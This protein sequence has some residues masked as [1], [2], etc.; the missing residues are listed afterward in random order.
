MD[1]DI[2]P[3]IRTEPYYHNRKQKIEARFVISIRKWR[4][5]GAFRGKGQTPKPEGS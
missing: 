4:S 2:L 1:A 3:I 5:Y